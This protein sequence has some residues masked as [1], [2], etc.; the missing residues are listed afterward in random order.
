MLLINRNNRNVD[1]LASCIIVAKSLKA[2]S[3]T[4]LSA[5]DIMK[6]KSESPFLSAINS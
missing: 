2:A 1:M 6:R 4:E 5:F 3:G